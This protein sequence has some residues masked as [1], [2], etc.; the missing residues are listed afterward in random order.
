MSLFMVSSA[1]FSFFSSLRF[2]SLRATL[3]PDLSSSLA[4]LGVEDGLKGGFRVKRACLTVCGSGSDE[5]VFG[6]IPLPTDPS[7]A[8][9]SGCG[10][11]ERIFKA[12]LILRTFLI[13]VI[14]NWHRLGAFHVK[15]G[16]DLSHKYL[17]RTLFLSAVW[18]RYLA[19]KEFNRNYR[20]KEPCAKFIQF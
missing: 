16:K 7:E 5:D 17:L 10:A 4:D 20:F 13:F 19:P 14:L 8:V 11:R 3:C 18:L 9:G 12:L 1:I 6:E 2:C 15:E